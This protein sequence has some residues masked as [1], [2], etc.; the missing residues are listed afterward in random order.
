MHHFRRRSRMLCNVLPQECRRAGR[1]AG[2]LSAANDAP[3][4]RDVRT[5]RKVVRRARDEVGGKRRLRL[6]IDAKGRESLRIERCRCRS[7]P[8][9][10]RC[11]PGPT[12]LDPENWGPSRLFLQ[13]VAAVPPAVE[14]QHRSQCAACSRADDLEPSA[15]VRTPHVAGHVLRGAPYCAASATA[16]SA[17]APISNW[18]RAR[19]A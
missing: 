7:A 9:A 12:A 8:S 4:T 18:R 15:A 13:T 16:V 2:P 1:Q 10:R 19:R 11:A 14:P 3:A 17:A 6:S 5:G